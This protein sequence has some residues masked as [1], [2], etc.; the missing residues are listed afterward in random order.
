M[1]EDKKLQLE[2]DIESNQLS[3][4]AVVKNWPANARNARNTGSIPRSERSPSEGHSNPLQYSCLVNSM[5]RGALQV[6]VH[7]VLK[8]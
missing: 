2:W 5:N 3:G 4:G 8:S 1:G 6:T 7:R